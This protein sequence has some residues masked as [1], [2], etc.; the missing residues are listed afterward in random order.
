[1]NENNNFDYNYNNSFDD[2]KKSNGFLKIA[3]IALSVVIV[4]VLAFKFFGGSSYMS[5]SDVA[6]DNL[7]K[8]VCEAATKYIDEL[9]IIEIDAGKSKIIKLS[10]LADQNLIETQ[11]KNPYYSRS[12]FNKSDEPKYYSLDNSVR[13]AR[14]YDGTY[15]CEIV[16]N[17]NDST[18]P[19]LRLNGNKEITMA[20]GT[21]Y[22]DPGYTATDDYDGNISD[23]VSISGKVDNTKAGSYELTYIVS[24]TAGNASTLKRTIVYKDLSDLEISLGSIVDD[25]APQ[26]S[27]KG[28]NPYCMVKGSKYQEPGAIAIDNVDGDITDRIALTNKVSGNIVG[29]FRVTYKVEDSSGN[30]GT[31]YRSVIVSTSC[32]NV[33]TKTSIGGATKSPN[34][35][36]IDNTTNNNN[37][38]TNNGSTTNNNN[39]TT[40][41]GSTSTNNSGTTNN[42]GTTNNNSGTTNNGG[43]LINNDEYWVEYGTTTTN[44][45][46]TTVVDNTSNQESQTIPTYPSLSLHGLNSVIVELG[47]DY[48]DLGAYAT[49]EYDNDISSNIITDTSKVDTS[50]TGVYK[51]YYSVTNSSNL[52]TSLTRTVTVIPAQNQNQNQN[53]N[54]SL[55]FTE[56]KENIT[57]KVGEGNNN[58]ITPPKAV[59]ESNNSVTVN[60]KIEDYNTA[61]SLSS[62][63]WANAGKYKIVYT[64]VHGNGEYRQDKSIIVTINEDTVTIG[65]NDSI[66]INK[67]ESSSGLCNITTNDL[68]NGGV[69][70]TS[71]SNKEPV[72]E[73]S[74]GDG[75][76]CSSGTHTI[77]ISAKIGNGE[78]TSKQISVK[79]NEVVKETAQT[80]TEYH[81]AP[82]RVYITSNSASGNLYNGSAWTNKTIKI[83]FKVAPLKT[84]DNID[85]FEYSTDCNN[86][87][88]T[89]SKNKST[90]SSGNI[91]GVMTWDEEGQYKVCIRAVSTANAVG[92]WSDPVTLLIDRTLPTIVFT[93]TWADGAEDW[94]TTNDLT[95][96]YTGADSDSGLDHFE[97]TFDDVMGYRGKAKT[98]FQHFDITDDKLNM[99]NE[100]SYRKLR[101]NELF[102]YVRAVDKAGNV[103]EW[104]PQPAFVNIDTEKPKITS[105]STKNST[106]FTYLEL[107]G[108]DYNLAS[109]SGILSVSGIKKFVYTIDDG[110]ENEVSATLSSCLGK[111]KCTL[112]NYYRADSTNNDF[113][114]RVP[115]YNYTNSDESHTIKA[116]AID[117]AGNKSDVVTKENVVIKTINKVKSITLNNGTNDITNLN[118]KEKTPGL[119][120]SSSLYVGETLTLKAKV[121][122]TDAYYFN[123]V[124]SSSNEEVT[125]KITNKD[126]L[127]KLS[128]EFEYKF[129]AKAPGEALIKVEIGNVSASCR[130]KVRSKFQD[131][132]GPE[133]PEVTVED[134]NTTRAYL[135]VIGTDSPSDEYETSGISHFI[136]TINDSEEYGVNAVGYGRRQESSTTCELASKKEIS[137]S[138]LYTIGSNSIS[139]IINS[140][141][142]YVVV[143]P[144]VP[145]FVH[146]GNTT[147]TLTTNYEYET[148]WVVISKNK[149]SNCAGIQ[150]VTIDFVNKFKILSIDKDGDVIYY[151]SKEAAGEASKTLK[152][153]VYEYKLSTGRAYYSAYIP[154][155]NTTGSDGKL[156]VKVW[157][158]D[159]SGN[160]S[161]AK[162]V[163]VNVKAINKTSK[164]SIKYAGNDVTGGYCFG[165]PQ[166]SKNK[167]Y[168][169]TIVP[170]QNGFYEDITVLINGVEYAS[171]NSSSTSNKDKSSST[172]NLVAS[173]DG[174][175]FFKKNPDSYLNQG[176]LSLTVS[177]KKLDYY[178]IDIQNS[179]GEMVR[180]YFNTK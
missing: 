132:I 175:Q 171:T 7:K 51:V 43:N 131:T 69:T 150:C 110:E 33:T 159:N 70:F 173:T 40:N 155:V 114:V 11:I 125:G 55:R 139:S 52:K 66:E 62:I 90:D 100:I 27:L 154:I 22:V 5:K 65:G 54:V 86:I 1:M 14:N 16:N 134:E 89:L 30:V 151:D 169:L 165:E 105:I 120:S 81:E 78:V 2:K 42:G 21:E 122:P 74:N 34:V 38:T 10:D 68:T 133:V 137:S 101:R 126:S 4:S 61:E 24:D 147:K 84:K 166:V 167:D 35:K 177:V 170:D 94:H 178:N 158:V 8:E 119:C 64:A 148:K 106:D 164:F 99:K 41:N 180:C 13:I 124:W 141:I 47:T 157:A 20:V 176:E 142:D 152:G 123:P 63:D 138:K 130:L 3:I 91:T 56:D 129:E 79:V 80:T 163:E 95:I 93:H 83:K 113:G 127:D 135:H 97:Y 36:N 102:V 32:A 103:G 108:K 60:M 109:Y 29:T 168:T 76:A 145:N 75:I 140:P 107:K 48:V 73:I 162:T 115:L 71:N 116:Y 50:K 85:H 160:R 17:A 9:N 28:S 143:D 77:N 121:T 117:K 15:A 37:G 44:N 146:V 53:Q 104:T 31:A 128:G 156:T 112:P 39:G 67:R 111:D 149:V 46:S 25:V 58:L 88:G 6:Y 59:N 19:I 18:A 82:Q 72:I 174:K 144:C 57:L 12:L 172:T 23:K 118:D 45:S 26:I 136:Y 49:D 179:N 153:N 98:S 92:E 96:E 87:S 161:E